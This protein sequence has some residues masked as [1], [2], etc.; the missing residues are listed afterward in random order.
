MQ[1]V[2]ITGGSTG[3][4]KAIKD[5]IELDYIVE[6]WSRST[7]HD[8]TKEVPDFDC[9]ILIC[10]AGRWTGT[11]QDVFALNYVA[12]INMSKYIIAKWS[13]EKRAGHIIYILSNAAYRNYGNDD[14]TTSKAGLRF[15]A[16]RMDRENSPWG[17]RIS[18]E[19]PGTMDTGF[20]DSAPLDN[21]KK[22][23]PIDPRDVA[24]RIKAMIDSRYKYEG[25]ISPG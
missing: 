1:K 22:C 24:K 23:N 13:R 16:E 3:L 10:N 25:K 18:M 5:Q 20:W 15:F 17:I 14:Y 9:D 21:R 7:G 4:G 12:P 19:S 2:L 6:D 8:I 11:W